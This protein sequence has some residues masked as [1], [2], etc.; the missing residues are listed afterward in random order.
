MKIDEQVSI[1]LF[2][3]ELRTHALE[4]TSELHSVRYEFDQNG[5]AN[6]PLQIR[7]RIFSQYA[8]SE[9]FG[10]LRAAEKSEYFND[11]IELES[12]YLQDQKERFKQRNFQVPTVACR[13]EILIDAGMSYMTIFSET[14]TLT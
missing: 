13:F 4:Q 10:R 6:E 2:E 11:W 14:K 12:L 1:T 9:E 5:K 3:L 8:G 7:C